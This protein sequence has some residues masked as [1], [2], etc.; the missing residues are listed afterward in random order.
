VA[1]LLIN[2]KRMASHNENKKHNMD[3]LLVSTKAVG[4][5]N[6]K[7]TAPTP[8]VIIGGPEK[9]SNQM[10]R[11]S[12][13]NGKKDGEQVKKYEP[14]KD[15]QKDFIKTGLFLRPDE[16]DEDA[17]KFGYGSTEDS[18]ESEDEDSEKIAQAYK[19]SG[20]DEDEKDLL[21]VAK[22]IPIHNP[23]AVSDPAYEEN[24]TSIIVRGDEAGLSQGSIL[25]KLRAQLD[26][27][28]TIPERHRFMCN[29]ITMI[30][31]GADENARFPISA[32]EYSA[33]RDKPRIVE[34]LL[35]CITRDGYCFQELIQAVKYLDKRDMNGHHLLHG[36]L[37][38][39]STVSS[40]MMMMIAERRPVGES[41]CM[42]FQT[43]NAETV[44]RLIRSN[45]TLDAC[46]KDI[47]K[48][49]IARN[50]G[51]QWLGDALAFE[52]VWHDFREGHEAANVP[53]AEMDRR[54]N[55]DG[56]NEIHQGPTNEDEPCVIDPKSLTDLP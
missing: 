14:E 2:K 1:L 55:Y 20:E 48:S 13:V 38:S 46:E 39:S 5:Q 7:C 9:L 53:F 30:R 50:S 27:L 31:V 32:L 15:A 8:N 21:L 43:D 19:D 42:L 26:A 4:F 37:A 12:I 25:R 34:F 52:Y 16:E 3:S 44:D 10:D 24:A 6:S 35:D 41:E 23:T 17:K 11:L 47:I 18:D 45:D 54:I 29:N 51:L 33:F 22:A 49:A 36:L 56:E 40:S 28:Q